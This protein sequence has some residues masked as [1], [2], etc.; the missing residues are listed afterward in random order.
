MARFGT[1][2]PKT[3]FPLFCPAKVTAGVI[4]FGASCIILV[5]LSLAP[6][7]WK[8]TKNIFLKLLPFATW[9]AARASKV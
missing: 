7:E 3:H 4:L 9:H 5:I 8:S 6:K 1:I 2:R